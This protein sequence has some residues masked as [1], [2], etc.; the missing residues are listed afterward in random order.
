MVEILEDD[1][2]IRENDVVELDHSGDFHT[3]KKLDYLCVGWGK[4]IEEPTLVYDYSVCDDQ[5]Y[6]WYI[7]LN[8]IK[9][10][11][12]S[13]YRKDDIDGNLKLVYKKENKRDE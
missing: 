1:I 2:E 7:T 8:E 3:I 11:I 6:S 5:Y 9:D 4:D 13:V 12:T 10:R